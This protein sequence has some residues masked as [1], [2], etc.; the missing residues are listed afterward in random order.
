MDLS[1]LKDHLGKSLFVALTLFALTFSAY[2]IDEKYAW[3][4][5]V[6]SL[7]ALILILWVYRR[8][9]SGL[10]MDELRSDEWFRHIVELLDDASN[11]KIYLRDFRHPDEFKDAHRSDLLK[12]MKIFAKKIAEHGDNLQIIAYRECETKNKN[13]VEWLKHELV[14]AY[15]IS[16]A[17]KLIKKCVTLI[18]SQ[19]TSNSSTVYL[20]DNSILLYNRLSDDHKIRYYRV[21]VSRSIIPY[22]F[23]LGFAEFSSI[24]SRKI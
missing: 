15:G 2:K 20:I 8:S 16:K 10:Y 22:L 19:P 9:D 17:N 23:N 7:V 21:D 4:T 11:A 12:I 18:N 5:G 1:W 24:I 13:P 3:L 14:N 6:I